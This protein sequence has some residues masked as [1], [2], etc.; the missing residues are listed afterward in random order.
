M[1]SRFEIAMGS[2]DY[3]DRLAAS[4]NPPST[5]RGSGDPST[6]TGPALAV[7]GARRATPYGLRA[8]AEF[9]GWAAEAGWTIVSGAAMGCDQAAHRAA[10]S[11]GGRTIAVMGCGADV[12][13]P[14]G[15]DMLLAAISDSGAVLSELEWGH[16]PSKWT[17]RAR[18]R[19]IA[20]L[21]DAL[22]VVEAG[23]PSGTFSTA[24]HALA[25]GRDVFAVPGS[26]FA[27][28]CRGANRLIRQGAVPITDVSELADAL[29]GVATPHP[30]AGDLAPEFARDTILQALLADPM[31]PDDLARALQL[32][33]VTVARRIGVLQA[34]G[35]V[36]KYRDGRYGPC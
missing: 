3:P 16:P 23:L 6:L 25:S 26:I 21:A 31:R 20:A 13:Y 32:D 22:L 14:R 29:G 19:I 36:A 5:L 4:P 8:A 35:L 2:S 28:E 18:N 1:N 27:S 17:F 15:A 24:D 12:V 30:L 34:A 9:A 33:V 10:L 7:V 11:A